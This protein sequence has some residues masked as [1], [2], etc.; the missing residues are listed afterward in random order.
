[1]GEDLVDLCITVYDRYICIILVNKWFQMQGQM[2]GVDHVVMKYTASGLNREAVNIAV[3]NYGDNP[4]KVIYLHP[5]TIDFIL[6]LAN[7]AYTDSN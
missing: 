2:Q 5:F 7:E 3:A 1:M 6:V 4:T